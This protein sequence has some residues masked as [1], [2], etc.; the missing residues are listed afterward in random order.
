MFKHW[1]NERRRPV[2]E[3][4]VAKLRHHGAAL[5]DAR[6]LL[7]LLGTTEFVARQRIARLIERGVLIRIRTGL[8]RFDDP[9]QASS[10][11]VAPAEVMRACSREP[12][13]LAYDTAMAARGLGSLST[14]TRIKA[15]SSTLSK[16][17]D[18]GGGWVLTLFPSG[19]DRHADE[20][21]I[22]GFGTARVAGAEETILD[23]LEEPRR[24]S[25]GVMQVARFLKH[26]RGKLDVRWLVNRA[27][28]SR[29]HPMVHRLG[30]LLE[31]SGQATPELLAELRSSLVN[32]YRIL[33]PSAERSDERLRYW[34]LEVNLPYAEVAAAL[35]VPWP[36]RE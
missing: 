3:A 2:E 9:A 18:L 11:S 32:Q 20:V 5:Y 19:L 24:V 7:R 12:L 35:G 8:Y 36:P 13:V 14:P 29:R 10:R 6:T 31:M 16:P 4:M 25:G 26:M 1:N 28:T 17:R 27:L 33:D 23:C 15:F 34:M 22:P 30:M 21:E